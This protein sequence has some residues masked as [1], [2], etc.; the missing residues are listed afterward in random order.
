MKN[1]KNMVKATLMMAVITFATTFAHA[2][3]IIAKSDA[4]EPCGASDD[5]KSIVHEIGGMILEGIIIAKTGIIIANEGIIIAKDG[6]TTCDS[7]PTKE[8]IIIA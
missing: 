8:G 5:G 1:V 7:Q 6:G 3:I 4:T 2:G